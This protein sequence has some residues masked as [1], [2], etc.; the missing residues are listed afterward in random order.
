MLSPHARRMTC[1]DPIAYRWLLDFLFGDTD[2]L[3]PPDSDPNPPPPRTPP[4]A[5]PA[6][7]ATPPSHSH[8]ISAR[9]RR[10]MGKEAA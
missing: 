9:R 4:S 1:P 3:P 7:P 8:S 6:V 5:A 2:N 10:A